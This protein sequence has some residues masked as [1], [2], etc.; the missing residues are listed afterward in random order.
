MICRAALCRVGRFWMNRAGWLALRISPAS[1][2]CHRF[3]MAVCLV[4]AHR[5]YGGVPLCLRLGRGAGVLVFAAGACPLDENEAVVGVGDVRRQAQQVMANLTE[6]LA[7]VGATL[8]DVLNTT[9]YVAS[10]G[11]GG[12]AVWTG[13]GARI[14]N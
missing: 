13:A 9:V 10:G 7:A 4:R 11:G 2:A 14:E 1:L 3:R 12:G 6:A 5:L 8:T